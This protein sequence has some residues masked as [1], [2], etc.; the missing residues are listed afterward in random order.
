VKSESIVSKLKEI[1]VQQNKSLK[2]FDSYYAGYKTFCRHFSQKEHYRDHP[3]N[4]NKNDIV[5]FLAWVKTEKGISKEL[6][7]FWAL[8]FIFKYVEPQPHKMDGILIPKKERKFP[9]IIPFEQVKESF[10]KITNPTDRAVIAVFCSTGIRREELCKIERNN[11]SKERLSILIRRGK[12]GKDKLVA[13]EP[14]IIP[15]LVEHWRSLSAK[16]RTSKYL[17]PGENPQNYI[18]PNTVY[19]IVRNNMKFHP[20]MLRHCF[21]TR[22]LE[23]G[24]DIRIIQ[25]MLGHAHV[26]TTEIYTHV[27]M[28]LKQRQNNPMR[29][30]LSVEKS[31]PTNI[32]PFRKTG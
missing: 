6:Q 20:H 3:Q 16:K 21:A 18:S 29:E 27:T 4:V 32:I 24:T 23:Q 8:H 31:K 13:L 26:T 11:I 22:L 12:G 1:V 7:C 25:E 15:L 5:E 30:I 17:F 2:T 10:L 9:D 19:R 28:G 14:F